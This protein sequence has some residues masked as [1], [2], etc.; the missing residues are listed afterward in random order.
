MLLLEVW[1]VG[2]NLGEYNILDVSFGNLKIDLIIELSIYTKSYVV[3]A[4]T[5]I[6]ILQLLG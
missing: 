6:A 1:Y 5:C 3:E 2:D 4:S